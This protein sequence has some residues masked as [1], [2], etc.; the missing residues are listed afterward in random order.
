MV[1]IKNFKTISKKNGEQFY[2]LLVQGGVEPV[3]SDKTGKIYFTARTALVPT[4]LDES[5]C[6]ELI[7]EEFNGTVKKIECEEYDYTMESTGETIKLS[8]RWQYV[9][10]NLDLVDS[11]VVKNTS[12]IK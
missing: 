2:A 8:H 4:T 3:K 11:H 10:D 1:T 12:K 7:G 9:D 5:T 6:Q